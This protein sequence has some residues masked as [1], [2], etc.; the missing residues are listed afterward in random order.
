MER[1]IGGTGVKE[2]ETRQPPNNRANMPKKE[3][4]RKWHSSLCLRHENGIGGQVHGTER[5]KP[6]LV[7]HILSMYHK[8]VKQRAF[9]S[10]CFCISN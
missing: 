9:N 3:R 7:E 6:G 4:C 8:S 5:P 10:K 2:S 1:G